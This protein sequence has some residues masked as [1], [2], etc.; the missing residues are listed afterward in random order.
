MAFVAIASAIT[1][2]TVAFIIEAPTEAS[3]G[4]VHMVTSAESEALVM[5][6][7]M[8]KLMEGLLATTTF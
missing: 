3:T 1:S 6:P 5:V 4:T 8:V 2:A 7:S